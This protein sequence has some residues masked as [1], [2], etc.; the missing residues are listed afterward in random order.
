MNKKSKSKNKKHKRSGKHGTDGS[1]KQKCRF[2][3]LQILQAIAEQLEEANY[4]GLLQWMETDVSEHELTQR[5]M[6]LIDTCYTWVRSFVGTECQN[7][8]DEVSKN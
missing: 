5:E 6:D 8:V 7:I 2:T 4:G 1:G 3:R